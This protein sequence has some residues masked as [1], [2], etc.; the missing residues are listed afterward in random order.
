MK[1][2]FLFL[3]IFFSF[4]LHAQEHYV[5][6]PISSINGLSD[7]RVR[8]ITQLP[9][10][11]M[12][13]VTE[14]LVNIYDGASFRYMHYDEQ[15]AYSLNKYSGFHRAY[16][17]SENRLWLKN[18]YKLLLFDIRTELFILN[19][20]SVFAKQ[21]VKKHIANLFVDNDHH[22][23]YVSQDDELLFQKNNK[24]SLFFNHVS[25]LSEPHDQLYDIVAHDNFLFL[26]YRSGF[27]L[28]F[29]INTRRELYRENPLKHENKQYT[30]TL[31]VAS[32]KQYLYQARNGN[33][34]G[35][36]LRF[37]IITKQWE[38]VLETNY[39]L[40]TLTVDGKG[41]CWISSFA[42][43]WTITPN[44]KDKRLLSPLQ[45][46]DGKVFETEIS[47]QYN[48][49]SGGLWVGTVNRGILYYHPDRFKF[50]NFG[51]SF[52]QQTNNKNLNVYSFAENNGYILVGT[53]NGLY[54]Y[55]KKKGDL[56]L[57][58]L[59]PVN[60]QCQAIKKDR[61][62][63]I[64]VCTSNSGLYC[65]DRN[66]VKHYNKPECCQYIYESP[67]GNFYLCTDKGMG[68]FNPLNGDYKP[69]KLQ[70][71]QSLTLTYQL[72]SY[73]K[74]MLLGYGNEGLFTYNCRT[75]AISFLEK[76]SRLL[77]YRNHHYHCLFTD[78][79]GLIWI[80]TMDGLNVFNPSD[81]SIKSFSEEDGLINNSIRSIIEDNNGNIWVSTSNGISRIKVPVNGNT[82]KY[83]FS[84]FNRFDGIIENE[85]MPRSVFQTS[86]N[87]I[88]W[89]GL[90]GL[91]EIDLS[92]VDLSKQQFYI[93]LFT[94]L[95][96]SGVEVKLGKSYDGNII[97]K[98]SICSAKTIDLKYF[99]NFFG[100]EFSAL[101]YINPTQTYYRYKLEGTDEK[102]QEIKTT[103]GIGRVNYTNLNPGTYHLIVYS[104]NSNY[105]WSNRYAEITIVIH[106]PFWRT[107]WAYAAY[108][109]ALLCAFYFG[110]TYY[111]RRNNQKMQ[112][113][114][115]EELDQM[116]F[117]FFTN[118]S[119]ELR[120]PL[121]LILT[122]LDSIIK[123]TDDS[124]LKIQ[125]TG[126]YRNASEL[127][128]MVNQLL[129]FR[130]L[131]IKGETLQLCYCN[132][133]EFFETV[134]CSFNELKCEKN[135]D[136]TFDCRDRNIF[137]YVDKDKLLKIVNNLLSNAFKFTSFGGVVSLK[138]WT[139]PAQNEI[140]IQVIDSGC[141][142]P[143]VD[144][145]HIFD[146]FY[147]VKNNEGQNTGS[148]IGLH[149]L[150]E[151][152]V[153]H[154]GSVEVESRLNEGSI[155][156]VT[157]PSNLYPEEL[158][159]SKGSVYE[160]NK[161]IKLLLV[162]DNFEFRTFLQNELNDKYK[163]IVASNGKEGLIK[164][165]SE[166]PDLVITD[167]MMPEMSGNELCRRL[168]ED[169]S[170]SHIP[171]IL[172]TAK[173]SDQSQIEGFEAGAD[174]YIIKPFNMDILLLQINH[175]IEQQKKRKETFKKS[176]VLDPQNFTSTNIDEE[177]INRALKL[178][179]K[180]MDNSMY[181]V[182]QLSK[183]MFMDRTSLYRK[184]SAIVGQSPTDFIRSVRLKRAAQL[185]ENGFTVAEVA[186]KVGFH[187][188]T[189]YFAKCFKDEFGIKPSKYRECENPN[190]ED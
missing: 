68:V 121:T 166:H 91:N 98:Q 136:F 84:S 143:E 181:S 163:V 83:S 75:N 182:E 16:V 126:I 90:D 19:V 156:T 78:S 28:C 5:F 40:N 13:I 4:C 61:K 70:S 74:D 170:V 146:R 189:S 144:L 99:Q 151:Y 82:E 97:L 134:V 24:L 171:V 116:K 162:E 135:I 140:K 41:N 187:G 2:T 86:D 183:D 76:N 154:N 81:N 63:R 112:K 103:D 180:N 48:D 50:R 175:L 17:D 37:N 109:L 106:P 47:T 120:T 131:E 110:I 108:I 161:A 155:F 64:W 179:E 138:I 148:G 150:K 186:E 169:V 46:Q 7:N 153:L 87:K 53:H 93:P 73:K 60:A 115:K 174:A 27:V 39:W 22:L 51:R 18:Q 133:G 80:G 29:D 38:R 145:P 185:L 88:F 36:L 69:A 57:I 177:L 173:A 33:N 12:V 66:T 20:D 58:N 164:A 72:T 26:F 77:C 113:R 11:R 71:G 8:T 44:L 21:G 23:W 10:G 129:D 168:K 105:R 3:F 102:W 128:K 172:L 34:V 94:R 184:L 25:D 147:Q 56:E 152:V 159:T 43:L 6:S 158:A 52:F 176:I 178:I 165:Q 1:N 32:Y 124:T 188:T 79:R 167:V 123:K 139:V 30:G 130:K 62:Q 157:I 9:D 95:L 104:A 89:G 55:E 142:I 45:L 118:I 31:M 114:Q 85:F 35:L 127:L 65:I 42:G 119:H 132:I 54:R 117:S 137:A 122:P 160:E 190:R 125:L 67:D 96:V 107:Y 49:N 92:H 14:G 15:K 111:I 141:G 101:N 59:I 100:I 149:L